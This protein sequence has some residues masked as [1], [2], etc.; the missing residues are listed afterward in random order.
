[1]KNT[2][3]RI[4]AVIAAVSVMGTASISVSA[5]TAGDVIA[6]ASGAGLMDYY[7]QILQNFLNTNKFTSDQYDI[8]VDYLHGVEGDINDIARERLGYGPED[9]NKDV[10]KDKDFDDDFLKDIAGN[11]DDNNIN[12]ILNDMVDAG[13]KLGLDITFE[14]K[15]DKNYIVTVKDKD[16]NIQLVTPIGNL[17]DRTGSGEELPNNVAAGS[18]AVAGIGCVGAVALT[19]KTKKKEE[20]NG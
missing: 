4:A 9:D 18:F 20:K 3:K 12:K 19:A 8:M 10:I 5:A 14:K 7:V 16:G 2:I 1:M 15:G 13:N 17:V 6:A 11:L